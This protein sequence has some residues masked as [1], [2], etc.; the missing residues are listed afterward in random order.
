MNSE[1]KF[2][3]IVIVICAIIASIALFG[4]IFCGATH[5][6]FTALGSLAI[7]WACGHD[8]FKQKEKNNNKK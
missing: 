6:L 8:Y 4:V 3:I 1:Q 2:D 7:M 5:Q